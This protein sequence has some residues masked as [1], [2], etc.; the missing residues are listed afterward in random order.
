[1]N[2]GKFR[3]EQRKKAKDAKK[4]QHRIQLKEIQLRPKIDEHDFQTKLRF[5]Q[6]FLD[7]GNKVKV[8]LSFKGREMAHQ[9]RGVTLIE[10]LLASVSEMADIEQEVKL[11]GKNLV[12]ILVPKLK[13]KKPAVKELSDTNE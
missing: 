2:Y 5:I 3:Y 7:E 8:T 11:I 9:D 13:K 1:M 12:T 4:K 6:N 10:K